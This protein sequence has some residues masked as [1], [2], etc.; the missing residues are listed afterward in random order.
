MKKFNHQLLF[1]AFMLIFQPIMLSAQNK[2]ADNQTTSRISKINK[3][4]AEWKKELSP[5]LYHVAREKGTEPAFTGKY[6]DNHKS[7]TYFCAC[8]HLPL[9][10]SSTKFESG[11]GW[12]SFFKPISNI[13][14][15][16]DTDDAYGMVRTEVS[17]A[18][19]GSHLGHVFDDGP[20]P[21]N[22]RYCINSVSL[23]FKVMDN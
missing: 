22:L 17:C 13:N 11:T 10:D 6:W 16:E 5:E 18:R 4:D 19:C 23:E 9:F 15:S 3:T 14:I 12:P 20:K 8:C 7:G 2:S 1:A 21:T